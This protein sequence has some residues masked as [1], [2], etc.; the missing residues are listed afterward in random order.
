MTKIVEKYLYDQ[1]EQVHRVVRTADVQ[2]ELDAIAG[3]RE[4]IVPNTGPAQGKYLGTV[5]NI[6]A[7]QWAKEC[8]AAIGTKEWGKYAK[9]K[10]ADGTWKKLTGLY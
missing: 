9:T 6:I 3:L 7:V 2:G 5:P 10:L 4:H 1:H 8:G